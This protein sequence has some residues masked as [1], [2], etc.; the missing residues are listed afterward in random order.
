MK[1]SVITVS[2]NAA[3]SIEK[4]IKSVVDQEYNDYEYI[5]IDGCS[6]D[7]TIDIIKSY[8]N[9]I[10]IWKSEPDTGIYNAM[11]KAVGLAAGEYCI[12]M[13]AGDYFANK[14]VLAQVSF[15][16]DDGWDV[17]TGIEI[18]TKSNRIIGLVYPPI[19]ITKEHFFKTSI[20]HQSSFIRRSLLLAHPYDENLKLVS[21]WKF[22]LE[23]LVFGNYKYRPIDVVVSY[24]NHDGAT[25]KSDG[26]SHN[27]R[28]SVI[29]QYF[30]EF[31]PPSP[32][33]KRKIIDK[34]FHRGSL[35]LKYGEKVG[36]KNKQYRV[37]FKTAGLKMG[38]FLSFFDLMNMLFPT[39]WSHEHYDNLILKFI[40]RNVT[41]QNSEYKEGQTGGVEYGSVGGKVRK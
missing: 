25:Y 24:F 18:S 26:A 9:K 29:K 32:I 23:T 13:N 27:E 20:S 19:E 14:M 4:T 39:K 40:E 41:I 33:L 35:L 5:I 37:Y 17:L 34:L 3:E 38:V 1:V 10:S 21:D 15:F 6:S 8:E 16:L 11:N 22:W 30:P 28:Q 36:S 12:F 7:G 31:T 2:F